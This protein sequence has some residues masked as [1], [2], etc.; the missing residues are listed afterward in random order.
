MAQLFARHFPSKGQEYC[1][2][3]CVCALEKLPL[4][5]ATRATCKFLSP[6]DPFRECIEKKKN[7]YKFTSIAILT[8][9]SALKKMEINVSCLTKLFSIIMNDN[10]VSVGGQSL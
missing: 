8:A 6:L 5:A 7:S 9:L 1:V 10:D 3:V 4:N 2:C